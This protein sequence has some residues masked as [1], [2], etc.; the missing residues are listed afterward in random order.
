M[1]CK[2][3][4]GFVIVIVMKR[5]F[6]ILLAFVVIIAAFVL[7]DSYFKEEH[8]DMASFQECVNAGYPVMESYPRRCKI[9]NGKTFTENI[10]DELEK[11]DLIGISNPRPNSLV[12]S[13]LVIEG[14]A[15]G[16]WFF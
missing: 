7:Y 11:A 12:K 5:V 13:P 14:K 1:C 16:Y 6:L 3:L 2:T 15:R 8:K 4:G 10:G 9:L